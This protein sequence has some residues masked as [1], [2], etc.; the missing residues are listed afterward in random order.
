MS[1]I[2]NCSNVNMSRTHSMLWSLSF[3][4]QRKWLM[5]HFSTI[6][7]TR[8]AT[9]AHVL[10]GKKICTQAFLLAT[11]IRSESPRM[12][13]FRQCYWR[14]TFLASEMAMQWLAGFASENG[15]WMPDSSKVM[16]PSSLTKSAVYVVR[17]V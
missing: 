6:Y 12:P 8:T 16:L 14:R 11:N 2:I 7:N 4:D 3:K 1:A 5:T 9:F 13:S 17:T 15:D 10:D